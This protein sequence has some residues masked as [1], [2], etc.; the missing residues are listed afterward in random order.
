MPAVGAHCPLPGPAAC[1]QSCT[2]PACGGC[3]RHGHPD[4]VAAATNLSS[5]A[6]F[7]PRP[8]GT[9]LSQALSTSG[10]AFCL[11]NMVALI[12]QMRKLRQAVRY[13]PGAASLTPP[14][15]PLPAP[16][17]TLYLVLSCNS[18]PA[19]WGKKSSDFWRQS[20]IRA[21]Q[22]EPRH[23]PPRSPAWL[24]VPSAV[25][26]SQAQEIPLLDWD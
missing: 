17:Q 21:H 13:G 6:L 8:P 26:I 15:S 2:C 4:P 24:W 7:P 14:H 20:S 16:I 18:F 3:V 12:L 11:H 5:H 10:L 22:M 23:P 19:N 1:C 25:S 9:F